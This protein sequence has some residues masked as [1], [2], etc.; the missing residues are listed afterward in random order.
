MKLG[1]EWAGWRGPVLGPTTTG[2]DTHTHT[3]TLT[4]APRGPWRVRRGQPRVCM[5]SDGPPLLRASPAHPQAQGLTLPDNSTRLFHAESRAEA[6][7]GEEPHPPSA[8]MES[9]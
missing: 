3:H 2:K 5:S 6:L 9:R 4:D 7:A 8:R 1:A